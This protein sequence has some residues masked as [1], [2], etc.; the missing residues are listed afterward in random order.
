MEASDAREEALSRYNRRML[1][2][3]HGDCE[4]IHKCCRS[5]NQTIP[6]MQSWCGQ[7][8]SHNQEAIFKWYFLGQKKVSL[9]QLSDTGFISHTLWHTVICAKCNPGHKLPWIEMFALRCYTGGSKHTSSCKIVLLYS[10]H[11]KH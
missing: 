3:A 4:S 6:S 11:I 8:H 2:W 5:P 10:S 9:L 7:C 1:V